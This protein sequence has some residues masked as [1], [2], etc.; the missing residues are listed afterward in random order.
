M[1]IKK[2]ITTLFINSAFVYKVMILSLKHFTRENI[3]SNSHKLQSLLSIE[4]QINTK[5]Y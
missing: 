5:G 4:P 1:K 2:I 3:F